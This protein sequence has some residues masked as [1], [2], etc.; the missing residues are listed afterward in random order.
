MGTQP[1]NP[2]R[3]WSRA[4]EEVSAFPEL[5]RSEIWHTGHLEERSLRAKFFGFLRVMALTVDGIRTNRIPSHA[6]ALSY[7]TLIALGPLIAIAIMVSGFVVPEDG[8]D[9]LADTLTDAVYYVVPSAKQSDELEAKVPEDDAK[10]GEPK[11]METVD[12]QEVESDL[13]KTIDTLVENSRSGT[14]GV[15]G[16]I[17]LIVISIQLLSTI[18]K[19]FN[20]IWGVQQGR[21]FVQQVVFYWAVISLGA[22]VSVTLVTLGVY[23][24]VSQFFDTVPYGDYFRS[25]FIVFTPFLIFFITVFLLA[26]FNRFIPNANVHW[27]PALRGAMVVACLLYLNQYL[28]FFYIGFVV[29]QKSLFG[30]VGI[31]PVLLF[32]L[33]VFWTFLL[34]GGQITYA[35]QNVNRLTHQRAWDNTSRRA[36]EL[37][38]VTTLALIARRFEN[39]EAPLSADDLS[40]RIRVP[41]HT[42][43]HT[44][45]TLVKIGFLSVVEPDDK[46]DA[47]RYQPGRPVD[48]ISPADFKDRLE[49]NGNNEALKLLSEADPIVDRYREILLH[50]PEDHPSRVS[51]KDLIN[52]SKRPV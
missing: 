17:V 51:F 26:S 21:N 45:R 49:M 20:T 9:R 2:K 40:E 48:Y 44:I 13:E 14:V 34:L 43:N 7:Y 27:I 16:S 10:P 15:I 41:V 37:L 8:R 52:E 23:S 22:V 5:M 47:E 30:A 42:L 29:R 31:L 28:S 6:A 50:L 25:M 11:E 18:E 33:F 36:Q 4:Q 39:C 12:Q 3:W 32:G 35:I 38:A 1:S 19:T 24:K 46:D